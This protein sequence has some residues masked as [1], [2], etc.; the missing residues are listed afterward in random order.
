MRHDS[1][2]ARRVDYLAGLAHLQKSMRDHCCRYGFLITEIEMVVVRAGCG[3]D[4]MPW[5]GKVEVS[6]AIRVSTARQRSTTLVID[7]DGNEVEIDDLEADGDVPLTVSLA[8]HHLLLLAK[9][10]PLPGELS[11]FMDVGGPGALTRQRTWDSA[12]DLLAEMVGK[13]GKDKWIPEPGLAEKRD[14]KRVRGWVV[15]TDPWHK[16]EGLGGSKRRS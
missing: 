9:S 10:S 12:F 14:A 15:P 4:G 7:E 3:E 6:E 11:T 5:F 13:D 8:L 2:P 16:R 1:N